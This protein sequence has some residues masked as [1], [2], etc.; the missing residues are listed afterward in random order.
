MG[1]YLVKADEVTK[2]IVENLDDDTFQG[3][4]PRQT[5][6]VKHYV[7]HGSKSA[8]AVDAGYNP[9]NVRNM[10]CKIFKEPEVQAAINAI[11]KKVSEKCEYS[12][13]ESIRAQKVLYE[14]CIEMKQM[15]AAVK[16]KEHLDTLT[17]HIDPYKMNIE[18]AGKSPLSIQ[19]F[20]IAPPPYAEREVLD[21]TVKKE[22]DG[23]KSS[24]D[25]EDK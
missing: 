2:N 14:T 22:I 11:R 13:E 4:T 8:A 18:F 25:S 6:F 20:G 9:K 10:A 5:M 23:A 1:N 24:S 19:I 7:I 21:A 17:K 15:T 16:A 12:L 3:L